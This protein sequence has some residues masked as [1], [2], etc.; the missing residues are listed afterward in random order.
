MNKLDRDATLR[1][2]IMGALIEHSGKQL[3]PDLVGELTKTILEHV[4]DLVDKEIGDNNATA[5][6][7]TYAETKSQELDHLRGT[8]QD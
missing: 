3:I 4:V 8:Y 1:T 7:T 6:R 2:F 5:V